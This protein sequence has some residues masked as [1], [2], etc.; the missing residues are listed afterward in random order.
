MTPKLKH[1][2]AARAETFR[3]TARRLFDANKG[4]KARTITQLINLADNQARLRADLI[5]LGAT[6]LVG[7]IICQDRAAVVRDVEPERI[8]FTSRGTV[9]APVRTFVQA[10]E[11]RK[12]RG[13]IAVLAL[14]N[15]RL[16]T[17]G[18]KLL[19]NA[20]AAEIAEAVAA[21][22]RQSGDMAHK[23][24]WLDAVRVRVPKGKVVEDVFDDRALTALFEE[25]RE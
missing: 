1:V 15:F 25:S 5:K 24:A 2:T 9:V 6:T 14:L 3:N 10:E 20:T 17:K 16:P 11:R 8:A 19:R 13:R 18:N 7:E 4:D 22:K 21:Y 12:V 23:A